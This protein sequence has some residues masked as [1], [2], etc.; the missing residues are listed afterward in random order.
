MRRDPYKT[1][2]PDFNRFIKYCKKY[3]EASK[4]THWDV[5]YEHAELADDRVAEC[6]FTEETRQAVIGLNV[7]MFPVKVTAA[8]IEDSAYHEV[9]HIIMARLMRL[10]MERFTTQ[11]D[12]EDEEHEV[13]KANG[14][15]QLNRGGI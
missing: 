1:T 5:S 13:I 6:S 9:Q 3:I 14:R 12:L 15:L 4:Y 11:R 7:S 10:S 2:K 8:A